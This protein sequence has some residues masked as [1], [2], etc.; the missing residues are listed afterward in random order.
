MRWSP[1]SARR[2]GGVRP[3]S[4]RSRPA[5]HACAPQRTGPARCP[6]HSQRPSPRRSSGGRRD[7]CRCYNRPGRRWLACP[8]RAEGRKLEQY[9]GD[10]TRS[11]DAPEVVLV[12]RREERC[13]AEDVGGVL[14]QDP[15]V[16]VAPSYI[17]HRAFGDRLV[18]GEEEQHQQDAQRH[19]SD[20]QR[21][22]GGLVHEDARG[23][24]AHLRS[25]PCCE[26]S[27][28]TLLVTGTNAVTSTVPRPR[29][30]IVKEAVA[31]QAAAIRPHVW[32]QPLVGAPEFPLSI[33]W[34]GGVGLR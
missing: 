31:W 10:H 32:Q 21:K 23:I 19:P 28:I 13:A 5:G 2:P 22:P 18:N 30:G 26:R 8:A 25:P 12:A 34:K 15:H 3:G 16:G 6:R 14:L 33:R 27:S 4:A 24:G 17:L 29:Q 7:H 1:C 11:I 9:P 20:R